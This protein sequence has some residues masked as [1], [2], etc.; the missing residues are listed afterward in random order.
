MQI[1]ETLWRKVGKNLWRE[2]PKHLKPILRKWNAEIFRK[3][4]QN[5]QRLEDDLVRLELESISSPSTNKEVKLLQNR[6]K[7][8]LALLRE[9]ILAKQ[10]SRIK[11]LKEGG[12]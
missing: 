2:K 9:E 10:K 6:H 8:E 1:L 4:D 7:L 12:C 3:D 5:I 11:L